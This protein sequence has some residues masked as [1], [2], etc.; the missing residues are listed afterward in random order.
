MYIYIF[1]NFLLY[2][3][4]DCPVPIDK[5]GIV[6]ILPLTKSLHEDRGIIFYMKHIKRDF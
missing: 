4:Q 2:R 3:G 5:Q 6:R 1:S